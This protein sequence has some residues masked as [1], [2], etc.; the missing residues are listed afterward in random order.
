ML[1]IR[2][3]APDDLGRIMEIY[4]SAQDFMIRSGNPTQWG[5]FYPTQALLEA[6]I[7]QKG[8]YVLTEQGAV[9]G[10]FKLQPGDEPTYRVIED[11]AWG[12][13][14]PYVTIHRLAGDGRAHGVF[15]ACVEFCLRFSDHIRVDTHADNL[16]MQRRIEAWG[17]RRCGVIHVADGTPR[18]A[19]EY[20]APAVSLAPMTRAYMHALYRD[21][22]YDPAIFLDMALFEKAKQYRY[23]PEK[24]DAFFDRRS[25]EADS[26]C[27]AV[28]FEGR[29]IGELG[30]RHIC[31]SSGTCELSIHLQNDSVKG[32]G[33]GTQA[34]RLGLRY[35][36]DTLELQA[37]TADALVKNRRSRHVLEKL[38]FAFQTETDGF[39][40]YRLDRAAWR[41]QR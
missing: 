24:V 11:G 12:S 19:Y 38:G 28:L 36:F 37:V 14:A 26:L 25:A 39:R 17:F 1:Q 8:A 20:L 33:L 10:V 22:V 7:A 32:R 30:L 6:D 4:R 35:A 9:H 29:V 40:C 23:S 21:F 16:P 34:E 41:G 15:R 3:A 18:I 2:Q 5:H 27:F 31:R 13:D